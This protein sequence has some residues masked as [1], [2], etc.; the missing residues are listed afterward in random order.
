MFLVAWPLFVIGSIMLVFY[1]CDPCPAPLSA[2]GNSGDAFGG[3][4]PATRLP[5]RPLQKCFQNYFSNELQ[6]G[7][8][9]NGKLKT[10]LNFETYGAVSDCK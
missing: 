7:R 4:P 1:R 2:L 9:K 5:I 3:Q 6:R 8:M 10:T